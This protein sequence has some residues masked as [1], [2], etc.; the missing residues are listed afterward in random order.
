M[1]NPFCILLGTTNIRVTILVIILINHMD[2]A[3]SIFTA[4]SSRLNLLHTNAGGSA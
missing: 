3:S 2:E 1:E 4:I